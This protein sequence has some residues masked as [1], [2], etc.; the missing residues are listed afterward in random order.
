MSSKIRDI[1]INRFGVTNATS[2]FLGSV[3]SAAAP[4]SGYAVIGDPALRAVAARDAAALGARVFAPHPNHQLVDQE[5]A[6]LATI[7]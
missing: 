7:E 5:G 2:T 6:R 4:I 3:R 1:E